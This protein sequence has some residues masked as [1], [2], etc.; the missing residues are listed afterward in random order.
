M[1]KCYVLIGSYGCGKTELSLNLAIR[2]SR[3]GLKTALIDLDI[4]NPFFRSGFH[5]ELLESEG[6]KLISSEYTLEAA[7]VPVV[8]PEVNAAFDSDYDV[9]VFDAGGDPVG[10][11]ALGQYWQ[12][13]GALPPEALEVLFVVNTR[14][15]LT[16]TREDILDMLAKV[17]FCA[18]LAVTGLVNNTNL[19]QETETSLLL[20]G[21]QI[22]RE[23]SRD[24]G[25][26]LAYYGVRRD[27]YEK[28][29]RKLA[30]ACDG[31]PVLIDVYTRL[32]WLDYHPK[33]LSLIH[34]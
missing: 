4:V 28:E 6:V 27:L 34:I 30:E 23:V 8:S 25:I 19:A 3:R 21:Q 15:P 17:G 14:R 18:R 5:G 16:Q 2:A 31:E 32:Q 11:T 33:P 24:T 7:D 10:A 26:P 9:A 13:F 1:K 29:E 22:L 12:K 20:E